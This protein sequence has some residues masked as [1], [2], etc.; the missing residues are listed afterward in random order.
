MERH[1]LARS[2]NTISLHLQNKELAIKLLRKARRGI[3]ESTNGHGLLFNVSL[4]G[5]AVQQPDIIYANTIQWSTPAIWSHARGIKA[6]WQQ[7]DS[8]SMNDSC[9]NPKSYIIGRWQ[10]LSLPWYTNNLL[11]GLSKNDIDEGLHLTMASRMR[12]N[13][14]SLSK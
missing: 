8:L 9:S 5:S 4:L 12:F 7:S 13:Y 1:S 10:G 6:K 2:K 14:F 11:S 3:P